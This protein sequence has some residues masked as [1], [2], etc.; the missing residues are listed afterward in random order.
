MRKLS[1]LLGVVFLCLQQS[2][3]QRTITG[4]V[5]DDKGN[6]IQGASVLVRGTKNGT[7][8]QQDGSFTLSVPANAISLIISAVGVAD[9]EVALTG[10]TNIPPVTML[11]KTNTLT[12][13]VVTSLGIARDKRSL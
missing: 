6:P 10:R 9:Q 5:I 2:A 1:L 11:A 13:V 3:Q 12:E 4:K 7:S 8:T